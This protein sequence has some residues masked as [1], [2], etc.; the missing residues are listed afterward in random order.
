MSEALLALEDGRVFRGRA[1]GAR[2]ERQGEV[3]FNTAMTG[4]QEVL[5]DPSYRGQ[6]VVMTYPE[7]GNYGVSNEALE[8]EAPQVEAFVVRN[9]S[10]VPSHRS[11]E[12]GIE[13]YLERHGVVGIRDVDTRSLTRHIRSRGAM[14]GAVSTIDL[15]QASLV[16]KARR[17]P[18]LR[19]IDWVGRV[20]CREPYW[21]RSALQNEAAPLVVVYDFGAKRNI[22]RLLEEEGS[23]VRVV[24]AY[25]PANEVLALK[26]DG[27]LLSNGPGDPEVLEGP[28]RQVQALMGRVPI[29]GICLGHQI[30]GL[31]LGA[32]TFKLKFGHHGANQPVKNLR[33]GKVE[34]TSQN[35]GYAVD[36]DH[37]PADVEV[38]HINLNDQTLEGFQHRKDP[39]LAVQYHPEASPGPH[40]SLHMFSDF[41]QM[42][43]RWR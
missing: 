25:T 14:R 40:D 33:S 24:P 3:V 37:L 1:L 22:L 5:T 10:A 7:I 20:T 41:L 16:E 11:A 39:I 8:S 13:A 21:W 15:D 31:A 35:H 42:V 36:P 28:V 2:G 27:V 19:D 9:A 30:L 32:R 29:L 18:T 23:R 26:P 43:R 6:I 4:Y 17:A 12:S 34:I 38:T